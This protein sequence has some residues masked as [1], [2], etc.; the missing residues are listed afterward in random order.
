[1]SKD[2]VIIVFSGVCEM[3]VTGEKIDVL[4]RR[5][6]PIVS[7]FFERICIIEPIFIV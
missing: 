3:V 2:E 4:Q 5:I 7:N 1:M 6:T